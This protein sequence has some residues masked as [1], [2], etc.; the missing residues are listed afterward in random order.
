M[1]AIFG[2]VALIAAWF[3][4]KDKMRA[5]SFVLFAFVLF[6]VQWLF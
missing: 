3:E 4:R 1:F 2:A 5:A 6:Y